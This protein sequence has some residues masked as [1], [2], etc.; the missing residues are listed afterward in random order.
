M[1]RPKPFISSSFCACLFGSVICGLY[2][3]CMARLNKA[4]ATVFQTVAVF[5]M[6]PGAALYYTMYG[7]V[8]ADLRFAWDR[9]LDLVLS[10]F[11]IVLGFMLVEVL[12]RIIWR[13]PRKPG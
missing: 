4:P 10:C 9:G 11:G 2:A 8:M 6:I 3:Q 5:P 7:I 1:V 13:Q 12:T